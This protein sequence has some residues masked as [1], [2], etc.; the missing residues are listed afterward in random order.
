MTPLMISWALSDGQL[1]AKWNEQANLHPIALA[2]SAKVQI[3][4]TN[5][6]RLLPRRTKRGT[7]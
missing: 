5:G 2:G 6:S 1:T 3:S 4:R 7:R